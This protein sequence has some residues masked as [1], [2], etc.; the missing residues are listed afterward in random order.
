VP[1]ERELPLLREPEPPDLPPREL[2]EDE[3]RWLPPLLDRLDRERELELDP[4]RGL[5][6][7][8]SSCDPG[9]VISTFMSSLRF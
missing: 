6:E 8:E 4:P 2:P 9:F 3:E 5:P 7:S 1:L